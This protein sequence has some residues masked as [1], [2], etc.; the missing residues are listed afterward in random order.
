M[1]E[2]LNPEIAHDHAARYRVAA[3]GAA[4]I[5]HL[6]TGWEEVP[7]LRAGI[8]I[9][10][11]IL[12][13]HAENTGSVL[14]REDRV[15]ARRI[16]LRGAGAAEAWLRQGFLEAAEWTHDPIWLPLA[17]RLDPGHPAIPK[18]EQ[19]T[20]VP[21]PLDLVHALEEIWEAMCAEAW[22]PDAGLC[23]S[24]HLAFST[25]QVALQQGDART[26]RAAL[27]A[28]GVN[29]G[30]ARGRGVRSEAYDLIR[31]GITSVEAALRH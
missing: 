14:S 21:R 2:P 9:T 31:A 11:G 29:V 19:E 27:A 22:V 18:L 8:I 5:P 3:A 23:R 25:A 6:E 26:A 24:T 15:R 20:R 1:L 16:L 12:L 28:M 17:R 7:G 13:W 10:S 30:A 4:A